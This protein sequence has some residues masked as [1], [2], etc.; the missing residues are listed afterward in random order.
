M[1]IRVDLPAPFSP[2]MPVIEPRFTARL[3]SRLA[4]TSPKRFSIWR[5]SIAGGPAARSTSSWPRGEPLITA[6]LGP[7]LSTVMAG[8]SLGHDGGEGVMRASV[9]LAFYNNRRPAGAEVPPP[10]DHREP[11]GLCGRAAHDIAPEPVP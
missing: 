2:T 11:D 10:H 9:P 7:I 3:T 6:P 1:L 5:S 8:T 4:R